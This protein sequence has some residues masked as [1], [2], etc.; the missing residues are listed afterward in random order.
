MTSKKPSSRI[1]NNPIMFMLIPAFLKMLDG[2]TTSLVFSVGGYEANPFMRSIIEYY[3]FMFAFMFGILT[4]SFFGA[5]CYFIYNKS[6]RKMIK[7]A[8]IIDYIVIIIVH[9]IIV[10]HNAL[11]FL[12]VI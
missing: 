1:F 9:L 2:Y 4:L 6:E 10:T 7:I 3:G 5:I 11:L 8:I 12:S